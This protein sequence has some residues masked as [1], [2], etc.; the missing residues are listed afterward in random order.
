MRPVFKY[1][2]TAAIVLAAVLV[3][4]LRYAEYLVNP[5]TRDGQVMANVIQVSPRVSGPIVDLPIRDNQRVRAGDLLFAID[6][7]TYK[8][9]L[10]LAQARYDRAV[11]DVIALQKQVEAAQATLEQSKVSIA[12]AQTQVSSRSATLDESGK[13]LARTAKL[14]ETG[15]VSQARYDQ[16]RRDYDVNLASRQDAEAA[17]MGAISQEK[18]AEAQLAQAE[19]NL[20]ARGQ[21]NDR[22]RAAAAQLETARLNLD[23]TKV[24]ASVD[25]LITNL[26]LRLGSQAVQNQPSLALIDEN[27]F[28]IDA[29]FRETLIRQVTPGDQAV[30]TLMSDPDRPLNGVVDSLGWG[31]AKE[32]GSK[33]QNLL[34]NVSPTFQWIRLA[35]R[36]PVRI[37]LGQVPV[38]QPLRVGQT[39]SVLVRTDGRTG[40]ITAAPA[41]L[42]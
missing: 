30:I 25:G 18:Q 3:V 26:D 7:R 38:D 39:A 4:A 21:Q 2:L 16:V 36:I 32:D 34:P 27:S 20:G 9:D 42:Q 41:T 33:A 8:S 23:F 14:L 10:E 15:D 13:E 19:A 22:L 24:T 35:Q 40:D 29:Y 37:H 12:R 5:W 28:W 31:I 17:L 11:K 1:L 6:P